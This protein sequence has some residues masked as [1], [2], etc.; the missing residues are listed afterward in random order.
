[1]IPAGVDSLRHQNCGIA[2]HHGRWEIH[3]DPYSVSTVWL[4]DH[5]RGG[6]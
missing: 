5:H 3:Y 4:R 2:E 6:C 1:M